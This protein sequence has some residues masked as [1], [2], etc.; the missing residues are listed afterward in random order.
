[1]SK[2]VIGPS[3]GLVFVLDDLK[4]CRLKLC[5]SLLL[6]SDVSSSEAG[7]SLEVSNWWT[8]PTVAVGEAVLNL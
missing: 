6:K 3:R 1:M 4:R 7:L 8:T 2:G 5:F